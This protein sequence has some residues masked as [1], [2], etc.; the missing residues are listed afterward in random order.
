MK[1]AIYIT[2]QAEFPLGR[3]RLGKSA[4]QYIYICCLD[5]FDVIIAANV[6]SVF[7]TKAL[8]SRQQMTYR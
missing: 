7:Q 8:C 1:G 5:Q 3:A 2:T 4:G 6:S